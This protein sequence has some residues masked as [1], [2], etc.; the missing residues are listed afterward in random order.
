M[1]DSIFDNTE[2]EVICN[3]D[4][5]DEDELEDQVEESSNK[6]SNQQNIDITNDETFESN[7]DISNDNRQE[8]ENKTICIRQPNKKYQD[9]NQFILKQELNQNTDM[10]VREYNEQEAKIML[11]FFRIKS[12]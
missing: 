6:E 12:K 1:M 10:E 4:E 11:M 5:V 8:Y 7:N 9:V 2:E 3:Y